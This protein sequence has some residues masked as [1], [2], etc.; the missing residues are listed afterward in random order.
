MQLLKKKEPDTL[1]PLL[2]FEL[3]KKWHVKLAHKKFK[4]AVFISK[5]LHAIEKILSDQKKKK[6]QTS[7]IQ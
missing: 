5:M 2:L 6:L 4:V 7:I 1:L 3:K